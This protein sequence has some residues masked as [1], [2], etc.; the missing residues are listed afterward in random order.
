MGPS[1][2]VAVDPQDNV[3]YY[4]VSNRLF[5]SPDG[6][7]NWND[8]TPPLPPVTAGANNVFQSLAV[9]PR[10]PRVIQAVMFQ[11]SAYQT[12]PDVSLLFTSTDG[13]ETWG[14]SAASILGAN[15]LLSIAPDPQDPGTW[16]AGTH[17]GVLKTTDRGSQWYFTNAGLR[18]VRVTQ[19]LIDRS[20]GTLLAGTDFSLYASIHFNDLFKSTDGGKSWTASGG[21]L[22]LGHGPLVSRPGDLSAIYTTGA[23]IPY[24]PNGTGLF[25]SSDAGDN[26]IQISGPPGIQTGARIDIIGPL[27]FDPQDPNQ[28][29]MGASESCF[30]NCVNWFFRTTDGGRTWISSQPSQADGSPFVTIAVDP[31]NAAVLYGGTDSYGGW[32]DTA[33]WKSLDQGSHWAK[34]TGTTYAPSAILVDFSNPQ[35]IYFADGSVHKSADG[36][37]HWTDVLHGGYAL[38]AMDAQ[39]PSTLLQ[40]AAG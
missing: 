25:M 5:K 7:A 3:V 32:T 2:G 8:I 15:D 4:G 34:L 10:D 22:P 39:A 19:M 14:R 6:G 11:M 31:R 9:H 27:A 26:W 36:G 29:Y 21:G 17:N 30:V 38:L 24:R 23:Y 16:Y 37:Q 1:A 13:G 33:L 18:A 35:T 28:M 20:A 40:L 12:F